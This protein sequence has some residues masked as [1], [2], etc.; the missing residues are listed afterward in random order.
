MVPRPI[1]L[2][3]ERTRASHRER[4]LPDADE[5]GCSAVKHCGPVG[6]QVGWDH[7]GWWVPPRATLFDC[8]MYSCR[9]RSYSTCTVPVQYL[10]KLLQNM[11]LVAMLTLA[12]ITLLSVPADM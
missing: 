12:H 4:V 3:S 11:L 9:Y 10:S 1:R 8:Y 7:G 2:A 5:V 6:G